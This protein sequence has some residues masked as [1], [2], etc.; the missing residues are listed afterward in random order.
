MRYWTCAPAML[1]LLLTFGTEAARNSATRTTPDERRARRG[2]HIAKDCL[3]LFRFFFPVA[4]PV[5]LDQRGPTGEHAAT[6]S[7][8]MELFFRKDSRS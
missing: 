3:P 5:P 6:T 1:N 7:R 8:L 2:N 4:A